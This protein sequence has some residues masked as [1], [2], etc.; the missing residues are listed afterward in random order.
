[1]RSL[2]ILAGPL[3]PRL[4]L[5]CLGLAVISVAGC[6]SNI[7]DKSEFKTA[8][9]NYYSSQ[10]VCLF[11]DPVKF[12]A[13]ADTNNE[14]QTKGFDALTDAGLLTRTPAEKKRFLVGSKQVNDYDLSA[15]GR[16]KWAADATQP[17]YGNFCFG[18]PKVTSVD[19]Y[20]A[21]SSG[22]QA[23]TVNYHYSADLPDWAKTSEMQMAFSSVERLSA[24]RAA[25][26][27]LA[28]SD[29]GWLVQN[30]QAV[31]QMMQIPM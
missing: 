31:G 8:L 25:T 3:L 15:Q 18:S 6:H 9:N 22:S 19:G 23:Y 1:M 16:S 24:P 10:N 30:V 7:V 17:G 5:A 12:P 28:K 2:R 21:L 14:E 29:S 20:A 4:G 11:A 13:Q 26:A 27:N